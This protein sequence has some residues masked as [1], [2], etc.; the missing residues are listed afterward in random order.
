MM[1]KWNRMLQL[2]MCGTCNGIEP[3]NW[4][5]TCGAII[6][7]PCVD[8]YFGFC[9]CGDPFPDIDALDTSQRPREV[10]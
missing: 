4:G 5:H 6:C 2:T 9:E 8:V 1:A 7:E 10:R 3:D